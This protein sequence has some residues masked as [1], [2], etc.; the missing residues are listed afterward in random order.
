MNERSTWSSR[1]N[2]V[3]PNVM[4]KKWW[5]FGTGS[6]F[7]SLPLIYI[8]FGWRTMYFKAI[9]TT[10]AKSWIWMSTFFECWLWWPICTRMHP[11]NWISTMWLFLFLMAN[12]VMDPS[13]RLLIVWMTKITIDSGR[14]TGV[15]WHTHK[16]EVPIRDSLRC[17]LRCLRMFF[18]I[19]ERSA[20]LWGKCTWVHEVSTS[21]DVDGLLWKSRSLCDANC[22]AEHPNK[23]KT[24]DSVE[25]W[26]CLYQTLSMNVCVFG[27]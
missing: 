4:L 2:A 9:A 22:N 24:E 25:C 7:D 8:G 1:E 20:N 23:R 5:V 14:I 3:V 21:C 26:S 16:V 19:F 12:F 17:T 27:L 18:G 13:V 15:F 10:V 11:Q 6:T